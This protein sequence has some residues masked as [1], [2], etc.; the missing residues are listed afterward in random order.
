MK[1]LSTNLTVV[2]GDWL[3]STL[4][5][6]AKST[7]TYGYCNTNPSKGLLSSNP[8]ETFPPFCLLTLCNTSWQEYHQCLLGSLFSLRFLVTQGTHKVFL[9]VYPAAPST[10]HWAFRP[11]PLNVFPKHTQ[12][13]PTCW[14]QTTNLSRTVYPWPLPMPTSN[15]SW[16][17]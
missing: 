4:P 7:M 2:T 5:V 8:Q 6:T 17:L 1:W 3:V 13:K 9:P 16:C 12:T 11:S 15:T 10:V 14:P